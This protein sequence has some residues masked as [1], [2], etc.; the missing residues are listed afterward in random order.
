MKAVVAA[1]AARTRVVVLALTGW[2]F[3]QFWQ[4]GRQFNLDV[5]HHVQRHDGGGVGSWHVGGAHFTMADG[6]V[7]FI[8]ENVD[9]QL[10]R[11]L[12][13]RG[14]GEVVGEF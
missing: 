14:G 13:T 9:L 3:D 8:S 10:Y 7:R 11:R 12:A 4:H 5:I 6:T 1:A 2:H